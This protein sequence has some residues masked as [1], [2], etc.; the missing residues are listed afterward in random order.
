MACAWLM[1]FGERLGHDFAKE[2]APCAAGAVRVIRLPAMK[3]R[4]SSGT[5][6]SAGGSSETGGAGPGLLETLER[7]PPI[8][9]ILS[10]PIEGEL[11]IQWPRL[12]SI[13]MRVLR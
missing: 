13:S 11:Q 5:V 1:S 12:R 7:S 6:T 3:S 4:S 8:A 2:S 10:H 9:R